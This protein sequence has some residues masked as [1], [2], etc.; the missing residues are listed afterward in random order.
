MTTNYQFK[1]IIS[2]FI[3]FSI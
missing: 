3:L 2:I 1:R